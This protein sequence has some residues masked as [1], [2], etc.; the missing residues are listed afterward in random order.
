MQGYAASIVEQ[1][2]RDAVPSGGGLHI[3]TDVRLRYNPTLE[4]A[5]LFVP[6]LVAFVLTIVSAMMTA[7]SITRE[8]ETGTMEMLLVS[9]IRP[10]AIV[11]GK[12]MPYIVLAFV[13]VLLVI[14]AARGVFG[15]P[16]RG[17]NRSPEHRRNQASGAR[18]PPSGLVNAEER[19]L[20]SGPIRLE[21]RAAPELEVPPCHATKRSLPCGSC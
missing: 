15:V 12:V 8:K 11:A 2:Y 9:P 10:K 13:S 19:A 3:S 6:G 17:A 21:A 7:I 5:H 1:W 4:S 18:W 16:L 14:A 20:P